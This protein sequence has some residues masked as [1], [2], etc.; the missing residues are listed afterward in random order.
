MNSQ[1]REEVLISKG[2]KIQNMISKAETAL[3]SLLL[4]LVGLDTVE[5]LIQVCLGTDSF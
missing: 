5:L 3:G 2:F 1:R 4:T